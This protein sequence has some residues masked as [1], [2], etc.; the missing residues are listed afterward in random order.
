M[1]NREEHDIL[2][3]VLDVIRILLVQYKKHVNSLV[4]LSN[5]LLF[6]YNIYS[7]TSSMRMSFGQGRR[8]HTFVSLG[9]TES[10]A[11]DP[12]LAGG[13]ILFSEGNLRL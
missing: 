1:P 3:K 8:L 13:A 2:G 4:N 7:H 11:G 12:L 5:I 9:R 6:S 10:G